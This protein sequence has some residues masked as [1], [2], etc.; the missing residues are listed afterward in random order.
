MRQFNGLDLEFYLRAQ[1]AQIADDPISRVEEL[2]PRN[3]A[4]V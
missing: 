2:L 1:L 3:H 4:R